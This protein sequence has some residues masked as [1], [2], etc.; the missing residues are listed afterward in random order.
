MTHLISNKKYFKL[1]RYTMQYLLM[2]LVIIPVST[3]AE[4]SVEVDNDQVVIE[5]NMTKDTLLNDKFLEAM[6]RDIEDLEKKEKGK[7]KKTTVIIHVDDS[8]EYE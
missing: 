3:Y 2:L 1:G 7:D 5:G 4:Q 8:T 6:M